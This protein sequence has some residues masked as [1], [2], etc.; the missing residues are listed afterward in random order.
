MPV[1]RVTNKTT[2]TV[3]ANPFSIANDDNNNNNDIMFSNN[4]NIM[5]EQQLLSNNDSD[6]SLCSITTT[7]ANCCCDEECCENYQRWTQIVRKLENDARLA[8]GMYIHI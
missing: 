7:N 3:R 4:N 1:S 6:F 2:H 5:D 8:A